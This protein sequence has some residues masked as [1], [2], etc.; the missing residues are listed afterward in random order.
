MS[1]FIESIKLLD[2]EYHNLHLHDE[3][4]HTTLLHL[5]GKEPSQSLSQLLDLELRPLMGLYK[6]RV[7]YSQNT[8]A[9]DYVPYTMRKITSLQV[10]E[11]D[12]VEY[13]YKLADRTKINDLHRQKGDADEIIIVKNGFIT[14]A[15]YANLIFKF[16]NDW[17]TPNTYL[18]N[19]IMRQKLLMDGR[20]KEE[21]IRTKDLPKFGSVKL[22]NAMVGMDG[23]EIQMD[24]LL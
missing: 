20:I 23:N 16:G 6:C 14:D 22:I 9:I 18:L 3:R 21:E 4:R 13:R 5:T 12:T 7:V 8:H 11:C 1:L 19:G 24:K 10:V 15:S 17:I 2:G